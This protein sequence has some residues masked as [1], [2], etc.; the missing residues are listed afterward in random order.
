VIPQYE[1]YYAKVLNAS[2]KAAASATPSNR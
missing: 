1:A 2:G